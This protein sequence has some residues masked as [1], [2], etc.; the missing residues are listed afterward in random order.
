MDL[1]NIINIGSEHDPVFSDRTNSI[2]STFEYLE[3]NPFFIYGAGEATH[4]FYE[5]GV[6]RRGLTPLLI[7]DQCANEI[8]FYKGIP[9]VD[10]QVA[11][12]QFSQI[13]IDVLVCVGKFETFLTIRTLLHNRGFSKVHYQGWFYE[14]HNLLE[15]EFIGDHAWQRMF[16]QNESA[17]VSA[18]GH[19]EDELSQHL[20]AQLINAHYYRVA[21]RFPRRPRDE[22]HFPKDITLEKGCSSLVVCGAYDGETLR[23]LMKH[24]I[25]TEKI[26]LFEPEP[27]IFTRLIDNVSKYKQDNSIYAI[28]IPMAT[29]EKTSMVSFLSGDGL[30]S[31]IST[32]GNCIVQAVS[33]D[34]YFGSQKVTRITMDIEG[35]EG[36]TL[37][38]ATKIVKSQKPDLSISVYHDPKHLWE[39]PS[40]ITSLQYGYKFYLRNYT[41]YAVETVLY[42]THKQ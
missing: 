17:I 16:H 14:I 26:F 37:I 28:A 36:A 18:Y 32:N 29:S 23:L 21:K 6:K 7:V 20:Y 41:S 35:H 39:I 13:E 42:A 24:G 15:V 8:Q 27:D 11:V 1:T 25:N 12:D 9:V 38:G 5:V 31:K 33:L 10:L 19:M 34:D 22:Q 4:W 40:L 3:I 2:E 30:G